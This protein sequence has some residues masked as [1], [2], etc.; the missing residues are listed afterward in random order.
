M[1]HNRIE[2]YTDARTDQSSSDK[3]KDEEGFH[4]DSEQA[5]AV[6]LYAMVNGGQLAKKK[7]SLKMLIHK[8]FEKQMKEALSPYFTLFPFGN[9]PRINTWYIF[10]I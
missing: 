8:I 5:N 10:N 1:R 9:D 2:Y 3:C 4:S 6:A 7:H